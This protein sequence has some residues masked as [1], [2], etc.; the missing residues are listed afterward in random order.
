M[1]LCALLG[2]VLLSVSV[3]VAR[4]TGSADLFESIRS[5]DERAVG[6]LLNN[7][8]DANSK[9][10][11]GATALM[12][13][14]LH[15]G[16]SVMKLLL[17]HGA[18]PN[19]RNPFGATALMWA[20]GDPAKVKLLIDRGADITIRANS[21]RS[22][23]IIASAYAGNLQSIRQLI[24]KGADPKAVDNEGEGPLCNSAGAGDVEMVKELLGAGASVKERS[25]RGGSIRGETPLIKA[26]GAN[27]IECVRLLLAHGADVN[28]VSADARAVQAGL[29]AHGKLTPLHMAI[30]SGNP[31]LIQV[32][33]DKGAS[34]EARDSRGFTPLM[35]AVT[36]ERQD[37]RTIGLLLERGASAD[38]RASDSQSALSWARKWGQ[39][40]EIVRLLREHGAKLD[41]SPPYM[42]AKL[43]NE[44]RTAAEAVE[45]SVALLQ[46]SNTMFFQKSGCVSCHHQ[47]LSGILVG[48]ARD[49][50]LRVN[51]ELAEEQ[52]KAAMTVYRPLRE[53]ALQRVVQGGVPMV[54]TLFLISLGAQRYPA[55]SL[56][57]A[58][59]HDIAGMQRGDGS[60]FGGE[61]RP[62]IECN[63]VSE[64]AYAIRALQLYASPGR[65]AEVDRRIAHA[66]AWL[67]SVP[68]QH[69]EERVMQLLGL[70]WAGAKPARNMA[71]SLIQAQKSDGGWAQRA[72]FPSDAYATGEALYA[73]NQASG[74]ATTD[75]VF[76]RGVQYLLAGQ[77]K[78]GSWYVPS[79]SVKFQPY[80]DSGFPHEHDQWIS[81]AGTGWAALALTLTVDPQ[82]SVRAR[83]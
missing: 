50:G 27:C 61:Q 55:D 72:G 80:F 42:P 46:V 37:I 19:A 18:D 14:A 1:K 12:H 16:P 31:D 70:Y 2:T 59:V 20:A 13:A 6:S 79:R 8:A 65:R 9:N 44:P 3:R 36:N 40:T 17:N 81:A 62:P 7:G 67:M 30:S 33:L 32:L 5:N 35:F 75:P 11:Q 52:L 68:A 78:D 21:G 56:T 54:N 49:R 28:A 48:A 83:R 73:L 24:A 43:E 15:A 41:D 45:R 58:L 53:P 77:Y 38:V 51:E 39:H 71:T 23:L 57:D 76:R 74:V 22:A 47:M 10:Q 29:Q 25:N 60:W 66:R 34:L 69:T 63:P 82:A 64:T 26:A 4:G